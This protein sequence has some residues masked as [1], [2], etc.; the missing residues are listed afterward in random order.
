VW[1]FEPVL[2]AHTVVLAG[3]IGRRIWYEGAKLPAFQIEIV[4]AVALLMAIVLAPLTLFVL[5]LARAKRQGARQYGLLAMRYVDEFRE[6]WMR[7]RRP[8][9]EPLVGSADTQSLA[10]LANAHDVVREMR[11]LPFDTRTVVALAFVVALPYLPLTLTMIP[12]EE[13]ASHVIGKLIGW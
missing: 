8:D 7:E 1:A 5:K 3:L 11:M 6:K 12:F 9:G 13:L 4:G 2:V 10:D